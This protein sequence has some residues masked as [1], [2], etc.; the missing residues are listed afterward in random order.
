[1]FVPFPP[2]AGRNHSGRDRR[3]HSLSRRRKTFRGHQDLGLFTLTVH[4]Q[5]LAQHLLWML[6]CWHG[7][8]QLL[9]C[10][11]PS[12]GIDG[13]LHGA[14]QAGGEVALASSVKSQGGVSSSLSA[15]T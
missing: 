5:V 14:P 3:G 9:F 2:K 11:V 12:W 15:P 8:I 1:M 10:E 4:E 13:P 6:G 7:Q